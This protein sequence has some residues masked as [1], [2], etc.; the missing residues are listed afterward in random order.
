MDIP[1]PETWDEAQ[2]MLI[3]A[4][5]R[6][7]E[8]S[9]AFDAE[10]KNR[11]NR[12]IRRPFTHC[13]SE[14]VMLDLP[15]VRMFVNHGHLEAWGVSADAAFDA[16]HEVMKD[17]ATAGLHFNETY[18]LWQLDAPDGAASARLALKGWLKAFEGLVAGQPVA[19]APW[20]RLLMVGGADDDTQ[21]GCL[22]DI[23]EQGW[24]QAP[25]PTTP[26]LYTSDEDGQTIPLRPSPVTRRH[27]R[28]EAGHRTLAVAVYTEQL[29]MVAP[30]APAPLA[31][32]CLEH[33]SETGEA[34]TW[35]TW[36]EA[37]PE[38][39]LPEADFIALETSD[40]ESW[41]PWSTA[42]EV[43]PGSFTRLDLNPTRY[44][45]SWP[46][47]KQVYALASASEPRE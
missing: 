4:I 38:V 11:S 2:R 26:C 21:M 27:L 31:P 30:H 5:R 36:S 41:I 15:D 17:H 44:R 29:E 39:W 40:G 20:R 8:P 7:T 43:A 6:A 12:L 32:L 35:V 18:G 22:L 23:A 34:R 3:P 9:H 25:S 33:H 46:T 47:I 10:R 1:I 14:L 24:R 13:L 45:M 37:E 28:I 16:A 19:I 42:R